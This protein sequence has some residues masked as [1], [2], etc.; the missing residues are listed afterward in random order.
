MPAG[1]EPGWF[2][3]DS[4]GALDAGGIDIDLALPLKR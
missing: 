3:L 2:A 1:A 4:L